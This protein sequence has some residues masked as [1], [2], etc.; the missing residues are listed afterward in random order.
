[1][2]IANKF[3]FRSKTKIT[4]LNFLKFVESQWHVWWSELHKMQYDTKK[5]LFIALYFPS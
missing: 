4:R 1:M 5:V 2:L 3:H